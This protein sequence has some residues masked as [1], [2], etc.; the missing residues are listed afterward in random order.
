MAI[1]RLLELPGVAGRVLVKLVQDEG[2]GPN[3]RLEAAIRHVI[4]DL[5]IAGAVNRL[6]PHHVARLEEDHEI[7]EIPDLL[8]RVVDRHGRDAEHLVAA[9]T[10][11]RV[12]AAEAATV[13]DRQL[14]RVGAGAQ[15]FRDLDLLRPLDH[16][17]APWDARYE[18]DPRPD[19]RRNGA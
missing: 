10:A 15:I 18:A 19:T 12:D 6:E 16:L 1:E 13:S 4:D 11:N 8:L 9:G 3:A 7:P 2:D 5:V 17:I 14:R